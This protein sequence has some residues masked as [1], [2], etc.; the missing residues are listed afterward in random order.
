[1]A[2]WKLTDGLQNLRSQVNACFPDRDKT[3]DG[4]IGDA[5]HAA[6]TSG[7][8]PDD[9]PN[10]HAEWNGDPDSSPEVR[11]WDMDSDLGGAVTAQQLVDHL[12]ALPGLSSVIRYMIY[13][14][15]MYHERSGFAPTT[16]TG[17]SAHTEHV[18]FSG[19]WA[20]A[21]D[22]NTTFDYHLEDLMTAVDLTPTA[23]AAVRDAILNGHVIPNP[24]GTATKVSLAGVVVP[25]YREA[26]SA[27]NQA[28]KIVA[29]LAALDPATFAAA[30]AVLL[31][32]GTGLTPAQLQA[33]MV[34]A[35]RELA[36]GTTSA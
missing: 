34:G 15:R 23:V 13:N 19:A 18:H 5:A 26:Q 25:A 2:T 29:L 9:V 14:R 3:S 20:Q 33:A 17:A 16:Y 11:A 21:A 24:D 32:P 27:S 6:G 22:E 1:M 36:A 12:R 7:H 8:D 31:P 10:S 30:V 35:F 4:T 28:D